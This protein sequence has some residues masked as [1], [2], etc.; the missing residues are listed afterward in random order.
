MTT[1]SPSIGN[2]PGSRI[3]RI[4][5]R[6]IPWVA[7]GCV[8][9]ALL[10][11]ASELK[12]CLSRM[13]GG[14][15]AFA[16]AL[17]LAYW[18]VN[19]GVWA[20]ILESL[21]HPMPYFTGMRVWLTSESL[22]WLPGSIW[23]FC[24]RVDAARRL[25]VPLAVASISLPL[26]LSVVI[27]SWGIVAIVGLAVSGL[28]VRLV[29]LFANW[30]LPLGAILIIVPVALRLGWPMLR[31]RPWFTAGM[32]RMRT[33]LSLDLKREALVRSGLVYVCLN[34]AHGLGFWLM[35][36][37]LGYQHTVGPAAA[38]GANAA[39]WLLG[40]FAI[41]VPGGIGVREAGAALL[42]SPIMPW[43]EAVLAAGLWRLLQ[44]VAELAALLPWLFIGVGE[45]RARLDSLAEERP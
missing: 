1:A 38:I 20:W 8:V 7:V 45:R 37:G 43:H 2:T 5:R 18:F 35:L 29:S 12:L 10:P 14:Y 30:L 39:G 41:G 4:V 42:L 13:S 34:S 21:G 22:R 3:F 23:G 17:C 27:V 33:V 25:G 40:F 6:L 32:E 15:L 9:F 11:R 26:E 31:R 24:T 16:F 28:G 36:A 19:A 44:I